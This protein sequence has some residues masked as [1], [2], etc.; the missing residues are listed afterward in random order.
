MA[1]KKMEHNESA[2]AWGLITYGNEEQIK[3][4]CNEQAANWA[5]AL[6]DKDVNEDG[7][8]K[9]AHWHVMLTFEQAK[10]FNVV[11]KMT[12]SYIPDQNTMAEPVKD[13]Q[14]ALRYLT[15]KDD[16]GKYQYDEMIVNYSKKA[17]YE[18]YSQTKQ[19]KQASKEEDNEAFLNDLL[20][21]KRDFSVRKMAVKYGRDFI[22]NCKAY[23]DF[24]SM[25]L[26]EEAG[27]NAVDYLYASYSSEER[28]F[29]RR[30]GEEV[31][32]ILGG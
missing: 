15:H 3:R 13:L 1:R 9:E 25:A 4:L 30:N 2:Y 5:Y 22:K 18:K 19:E 17:W 29:I 24:R 12:K 32:E 6:H 16:Q 31:N 8:P 27:I 23:I 10:S 11:C 14:G 7:K 28:E 26:A 20:C 21:P